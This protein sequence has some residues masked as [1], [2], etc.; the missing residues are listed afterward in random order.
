MILEVHR[1]KTLYKRGREM[2]R[3]ADAR[4]KLKIGNLIVMVGLDNMYP[5][6][7]NTLYGMLVWSKYTLQNHLDILD[8]WKCKGHDMLTGKLKEESKYQYK[9]IE[10]RKAENRKKIWIGGLFVKAGL[11]VMYPK[12]IYILYGM[13]VWCKEFLEENPD[14]VDTWKKLGADLEQKNGEKSD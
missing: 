5:D 10:N 13:I 11:D 3:K 1:L 14:I 2:D 4:K 12:E 8:L 9:V 7:L 6:Q